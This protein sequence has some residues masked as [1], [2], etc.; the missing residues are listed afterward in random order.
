MTRKEA[1]TRI[2]AW[3][4]N[5]LNWSKSRRLFFNEITKLENSKI[6]TKLLKHNFKLIRH[7]S[8]MLYEA[9]LT[10]NNHKAFMQIAEEGV[11]INSTILNRL[12]QLEESQKKFF[13]DNSVNQMHIWLAFFLHNPHSDRFFTTF[14]DKYSYLSREITKNQ[15][16][17]SWLNDFYIR[18]VEETQN[19]KLPQ[20][21]KPELNS[22][23]Q[24]ISKH[25][26]PL[27]VAICLK[28]NKSG[29]NLLYKDTTFKNIFDV[30]EYSYSP[31]IKK[32]LENTDIKNLLANEFTSIMSDITYKY[33]GNG[34]EIFAQLI[35]DSIFRINLAK[36]T[37]K[38]LFNFV[39]TFHNFESLKSLIRNAMTLL[40]DRDCLMDYLIQS[41]NFLLIDDINW[42]LYQKDIQK[43]AMKSN[44][45][46]NDSILYGE[47]LLEI[48]NHCIR[49]ETPNSLKLLSIFAKLP[50]NLGLPRRFI[51]GVS[52]YSNKKSD[53]SN[54][55]DNTCLHLALYGGSIKTALVLINAGVSVNTLNS[56]GHNALFAF[57][58]DPYYD[59]ERNK[60]VD[61]VTW[62]Y[63]PSTE[64][65]ELLNII[66]TKTKSLEITD[67]EGLLPIHYAYMNGFPSKISQHDALKT[68]YKLKPQSKLKSAPSIDRIK[69]WY[70][71]NIIPEL[72]NQIE[73]IKNTQNKSDYLSLF[74]QTRWKILQR[75]FH[76]NETKITQSALQLINI[77]SLKTNI[78]TDVH[79][80]YGKNDQ[81]SLSKS[82]ILNNIL[83]ER[84]V[85]HKINSDWGQ[86]IGYYDFLQDSEH[87]LSE[88]T[89]KK[90]LHIRSLLNECARSHLPNLVKNMHA[91]IAKELASDKDEDFSNMKKNLESFK[92]IAQQLSLDNNSV[93]KWINISKNKPLAFKQLLYWMRITYALEIK[94]RNMKKQFLMVFNC[95][96]NM[97]DFEKKMK[98]F[99][100][101]YISKITTDEIHRLKR[102]CSMAYAEGNPEH[103]Y[104]KMSEIITKSY[105]TIDE[106]L[107][108]AASIILDSISAYR[109]RRNINKTSS[110][111]KGYKERTVINTIPLVTKNNTNE[112]KWLATLKSEAQPPKQGLEYSNTQKLIGVKVLK[113]WNQHQNAR[114]QSST[115]LKNTNSQQ[116]EI[117]MQACLYFLGEINTEIP[118]IFFQ[119]FGTPEYWMIL[120][121][122]CENA[123]LDIKALENEFNINKNIINSDEKQLKYHDYV[124]N[125]YP[126]DVNQLKKWV[127]THRNNILT[128]ND[129]RQLIQLVHAI[130]DEPAL[131]SELLRLAAIWHDDIMMSFLTPFIKDIEEDNLYL[132][133]YITKSD[134]VR[135]HQSLC[136]T[137]RMPETSLFIIHKLL[138]KR[139]SQWLIDQIIKS[140]TISHD[141]VMKIPSEYSAV[142][143]VETNSGNYSSDQMDWIYKLLNNMLNST[144]TSYSF[145]LN[146][147]QSFSGSYH[148][149][150]KKALYAK[151][152]NSVSPLQLL[153]LPHLKDSHREEIIHFYLDIDI[154]GP[155][156]L[157]RE[158]TK[159]DIS[160]QTQKNI[161]L[162]AIKMLNSSP[163]EKLMKFLKLTTKTISTT[164]GHQ[165]TQFGFNILYNNNPKNASYLQ[166]L[167]LFSGS[168]SF[169]NIEHIEKGPT[170]KKL[171]NLQIRSLANSCLKKIPISIEEILSKKSSL[172]AS[173]HPD[174]LIESSWC[175][176]S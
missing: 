176:L 61:F 110:C 13:F 164:D 161:V 53:V 60:T 171:N 124:K 34:K 119:T 4:R 106:Y 88:N 101:V 52:T 163:S 146:L 68:F 145:L 59:R 15:I 123:Q 156:G 93:E 127:S 96:N 92:K 44:P 86:S 91:L 157:Y 80:H 21:I 18:L 149:T 148:T 84:K 74:Y 117:L 12:L 154:H 17:Q 41:P 114:K 115:A 87:S 20:G 65:M 6:L 7:N 24:G 174:N 94:Y 100:I 19:Q 113:W 8:S 89:H 55:T 107:E 47:P 175:I 111:A 27:N 173:K 42:D 159:H 58:F 143:N 130:K 147:I 97:I 142:F 133:L 5:N 38:V 122:Y 40:I 90:I 104:Y 9:T 167:S 129:L 153:K 136:V 10:N 168:I 125:P 37:N 160:I 139:T 95:Q 36:L 112:P 141:L 102:E 72:L 150:R 35:N 78:H 22:L 77:M 54:I 1:L 66:V 116:Q 49:Y 166:K 82:I 46:R 45:F 121:G 138:D 75:W 118:L 76:E 51:D 170:I 16:N 39:Y 172:K 43:S 99:S 73:F 131:L 137:A 62:K 63:Q 83:K 32:E 57:F 135:I 14:K 134:P 85:I 28:E 155:E 81:S 26:Q 152:F 23:R 126:Q 25:I 64:G 29:L 48:C 30:I 105:E 158:I 69:L 3:L 120:L 169:K 70:D 56:V 71:L 67:N 103:Y 132:T 109:A 151:L 108:T 144:I 98:D 79:D 31:E 33:R 2:L 128:K 140:N 50:F 165:F 11:I 162:C